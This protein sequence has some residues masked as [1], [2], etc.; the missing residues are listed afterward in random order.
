M[1]ILCKPPLQPASVKG[2]GNKLRGTFYKDFYCSM[3]IPFKNNNNNK[4][5]PQRVQYNF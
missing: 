5:F 4:I 2:A 1:F 3:T